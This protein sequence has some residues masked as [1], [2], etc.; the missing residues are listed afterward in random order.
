MEGSTSRD[1]DEQAR[2]LRRAHREVATLRERVAQLE[3]VVAQI[4]QILAP[5]PDRKPPRIVGT[6]SAGEPI[7]AREAGEQ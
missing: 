3:R 7:F 2:E 6:D 5:R 1:G 4:K